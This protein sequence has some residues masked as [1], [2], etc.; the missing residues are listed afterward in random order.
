MIK[1]MSLWDAHY[2]TCHETGFED[3][4][5]LLPQENLELIY[6]M[7]YSN[8]FDTK[9]QIILQACKHRSISKGV[10]VFWRIIG[11]SRT[12]REWWQ[13]KRCD[14]HLPQNKL[15]WKNDVID[16]TEDWA[17]V[18]FTKDMLRTEWE[19]DY[20]EVKAQIR[21]LTEIQQSIRGMK[22]IVF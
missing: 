20:L 2:L 4:T 18:E 10:V 22:D 14:L 12:D 15:G 3:P 16:Y 6:G 1:Y 13:D 11:W 19:E 5:Y 21:Q 8:G 9:K 7:L 17:D